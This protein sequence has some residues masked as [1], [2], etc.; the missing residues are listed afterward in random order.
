[1][2]Q[3]V[4]Q[5]VHTRQVS[6]LKAGL[7]SSHSSFLPLDLCIMLL[8]SLA[9]TLPCGSLQSAQNDIFKLIIQEFEK[10]HSAL[11]VQVL[12]YETGG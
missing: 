10:K 11:Y 1:M 8:L 12:L 3:K 9:L 2:K 4:G 6:R 5:V 7:C